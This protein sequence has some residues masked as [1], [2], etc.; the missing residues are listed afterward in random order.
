MGS[1]GECFCGECPIQHLPQGCWQVEDDQG[2]LRVE[3]E[4]PEC[5]PHEEFERQKQKCMDNDGHIVINRDH[6]GCEFIECTFGSQYTQGSGFDF[7]SGPMECPSPEEIMHMERKCKEIG[8]EPRYMFDRG[9]KFVKCEERGFEKRECGLVPGPER[10]AMERKCNEQGLGII[11]DFDDRGC[12]LMRCGN[13]EDCPREPPQEAFEGCNRDGGEFIVKRDSEGCVSFVNC[14]MRGDERDIYVGQINE[15]P[16]SSELLAMAFKLENLNIELDKLAK[17]ADDIADYYASTGSP[18][19]EK[20]RRVADM[21]ESMKGKVNEI[22]NKLSSRLEYLTID[23]IMEIK[24]DI[25][26]LKDVMIKDIVYLMLSTGDDIETIEGNG[27]DDC[28]TDGWCF[29]NA[30]RVCKQVTFRPEGLSG[31]I[32]EIT[33]LEGDN[34]IVKVTLPEG[35][36]P[37]AGMIPGIN[38]PYDMTC[39]IK[40]YS[41]GIRDH[42]EDLLPYCEGPMMTLMEMFPEGEGQDRGG[43]GG[44]GPSGPGGPSGGPGEYRDE[45]G[46]CGDGRCEGQEKFEPETCPSDCGWMLGFDCSPEGTPCPSNPPCCGDVPCCQGICNSRC[47]PQTREPGVYQAERVYTGPCSGCL[48]NGICDPGECKDCMDCQNVDFTNR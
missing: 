2:F 28:G 47:A 5:P 42:E 33:G 43:P 17:E 35:E 14:V 39:T 41:L 48:D 20:Y 40:D 19:E 45:Y 46:F 23:D 9:C 44:P 12:Q 11:M 26:Y 24:H 1:N 22:K 3:C 21:F 37:P 8:S 15:M 4:K 29:D 7:G 27:E 34:C 13:F 31:P 36:G 16:E 6:R 10:E 38:P 30:L 32:V 18:Q 25:R